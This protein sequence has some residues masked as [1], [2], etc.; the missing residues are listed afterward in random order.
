VIGADEQL[1]RIAEF[2]RVHGSIV[3]EAREYVGQMEMQLKNQLEEERASLRTQAE[4]FV[5]AENESLRKRVEGLEKQVEGLEKQVDTLDKEVDTL[6]KRVDTLEKQVDTLEQEVST[7]KVENAQSTH[8]REEERQLCR[9]QLQQT[10]SPPNQ[11]TQV[12]PGQRDEEMDGNAHSHSA[13]ENHN[14]SRYGLT[15]S[16]SADQPNAAKP[17]TTGGPTNQGS[18]P[19]TTTSTLR[20]DSHPDYHLQPPAPS[21]YNGPPPNGTQ[22]KLELGDLHGLQTTTSAGTSSELRQAGGTG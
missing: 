4:E 19:K 3:Q 10:H 2:G 11:Q 5:A 13:D 9:E 18:E 8:Q 20:P 21:A 6:E 22:P 15:D 14:T 17:Q 16:G 7:L 12:Q 1:K